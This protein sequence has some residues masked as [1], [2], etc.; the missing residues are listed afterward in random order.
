MIKKPKVIHTFK[1]HTETYRIVM[2]SSQEGRAFQYVYERM[3]K[4]ALEEE[5]WVHA[6]TLHNSQG[7][8]EG[9]ITDGSDEDEEIALW[10]ALFEMRQRPSMAQV[11]SEIN[12]SKVAHPSFEAHLENLSQAIQERVREENNL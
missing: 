1:H 3:Y 2:V 8:R 10:Q 6:M 11:I 5:C 9:Q 12:K 7:M 4:D